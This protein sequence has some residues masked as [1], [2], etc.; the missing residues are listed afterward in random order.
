MSLVA[1]IADQLHDPAMLRSVLVELLRRGVRAYETLLLGPWE[2]DSDRRDRYVRR[3]LLRRC[4][5]ACVWGPVEEE[6]ALLYYGCIEDPPCTDRQ[7]EEGLAT[8]TDAQAAI[9]ALAV[10]GGWYLADKL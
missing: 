3:D 9:D 1:L 6:G 4:V 2:P 7:L 10:D 8:L 5:V